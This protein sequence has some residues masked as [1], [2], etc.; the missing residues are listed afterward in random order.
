MLHASRLAAIGE[1][2]AIV[3]H[4][5]N[6]PL[7]AIL[8]N[9]QAIRKL[10]Q[11]PHL[12][13]GEVL[14]IL[15]ELQQDVMRAR[16]IV[17]R[18]RALSQKRAAEIQAG[19]INHL[20]EEVV[21]LAAG[22]AQQRHVQLRTE[23]EPQLPYVQLDPVLIEHVLLN[24]IANGMESM[25]DLPTQKRVLTLKTEGLPNEGFI[26]ISVKDRGRGIPA[27]VFPLIFNSFFSTKE[28]G[29]GLGLSVAR[30]LIQAHHGRIWAENNLDQGATF[31]F[32]LPAQFRAESPDENQA[33]A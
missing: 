29:V 30:T 13:V 18:L 2:T 21:R 4:E 9:I 25:S 27:E 24:L 33:G 16:D 1:F 23:L 8:I 14:P 15:N 19:D 6:Q 3:S 5:V 12:P 22:D 10:A 32:C 26:L 17:S 11:Q 31:R 20:I 28:A 7:A